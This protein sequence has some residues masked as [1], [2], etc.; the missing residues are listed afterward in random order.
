MKICLGL[1]NKNDKFF[2]ERHL[3]II[4]PCFD[5]AVVVDAESTDGSQAVL[6]KHGFTIIGR[7]WTNHFADARNMVIKIAEDLKYTHIF[8][9]DADEWMTSNVIK[10]TK[11]L[12]KKYD[13]DGIITNR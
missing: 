4:R 3:P 6:K 8:F 5:G 13:P 11:A 12:F 1:I 2:L 7:P 10:N 9:L